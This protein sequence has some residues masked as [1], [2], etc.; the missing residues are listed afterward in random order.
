[1]NHDGGRSTENSDA[2]QR[3][4]AEAADL[5]GRVVFCVAVE[6]DPAL[7]QHLR[8]VAG[9]GSDEPLLVQPPASQVWLMIGASGRLQ[10]LR[11]APGGVR[12]VIADEIGGRNGGLGRHMMGEA[13]IRVRAEALGLLT[14]VFDTE[15][16]PSPEQITRLLR[17]A[18]VIEKVA[19]RYVTHASTLIDQL[20]RAVLPGIDDPSPSRE[21]ELLDYWSCLHRM[22]HLLTIA[23]TPGARPWLSEMAASFTWVTWTP[24]FTLL[25]ER[26]LWLTAAAA[27]SAVAFGESVTGPYLVKLSSSDHPFKSFDALVGLVA[28]GLD[29]PALAGSL[30]SELAVIKASVLRKNPPGAFHVRLMLDTAIATLREPDASEQRFLERDRGARGQELSGTAELLGLDVLSRD[31]TDFL[32]S[33]EAL[34]L[35]ALPTIIRSDPADYYPRRQPTH[36]GFMIAPS[37]IKEILKRAWGPTT[38]ADGPTI[39]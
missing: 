14:P 4:I 28:I 36:R 20:R 8:R 30:V 19:Y 7:R 9:A 3:M 31:P 11:E 26:T 23:S 32:P 13:E 27:K 12:R 6:R 21:G 16:S 25:R 29:Q 35:V 2:R 22:G 1:V 10:V 18:P 5:V 38:L 17:W 39:H 37:E 33:G 15:L 24:T 34:G